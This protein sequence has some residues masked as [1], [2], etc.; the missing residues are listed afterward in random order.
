MSTA[1][2]DMVA[3]VRRNCGE[4]GR[5]WGTREE[6]CRSNSSPPNI[7]RLS[8]SH[9][10]FASTHAEKTLQSVAQRGGEVGDDAGAGASTAQRFA[11]TLGWIAA[12]WSVLLVSRPLPPTCVFLELQ[13][14]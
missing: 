7:P 4:A 9:R 6:G 1:S 13:R 12:A 14:K 11:P 8:S 5:G 3:G 2:F 10:T